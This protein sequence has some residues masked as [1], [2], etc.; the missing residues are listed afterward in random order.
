MDILEILKNDY[1][2]FPNDQTYSLYAPDVYFKDPMTEFR[3]CDRYRQM[4]HFIKTW[5]HNPQLD[6][7][8]IQRTGDS[9]RTDWTLS[10][11]TPLPWRPRIA[12]AGWSELQLNNEELII[13]HIDY[14][15]C[16]KLDVLKQ[17]IGLKNKH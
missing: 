8:A 5:F 3:G 15:N 7:H 10:W 9:I 4:I 6:L 17:H 1:R 12:I 2:N 14:W 16:S 11:T 13:S